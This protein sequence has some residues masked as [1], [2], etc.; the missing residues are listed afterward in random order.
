MRVI[1]YLLGHAACLQKQP[2][3]AVWHPIT[4]RSVSKS[5][6]VQK[7]AADHLGSS[8][9]MG[10][11]WQPVKT[12]EQTSVKQMELHH[13]CGLK[14]SLCH[15]T[16]SAADTFIDSTVKC[17]CCCKSEVIIVGSSSS[18]AVMSVD[19]Q[20]TSVRS[21]ATIMNSH[22]LLYWLCWCST[23]L[24]RWS[25]S[26]RGDR[27]RDKFPESHIHSAWLQTVSCGARP[28]DGAVWWAWLS[29]QHKHP[30]ALIPARVSMMGVFTGLN[31]YFWMNGSL[32][33]TAL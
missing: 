1:F 26:Q 21:T 7:P 15:M 11:L 16:H 17:A 12:A 22:W 6:I 25:I 10:I 24:C 27:E 33:I 30:F 19:T 2:H 8:A 5:K 20:H 29:K 14:W 18:C 3:F 31:P 4:W 32:H 13:S 28:A 9:C 23:C